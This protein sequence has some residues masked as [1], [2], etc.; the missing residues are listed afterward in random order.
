M[1]ENIKLYGRSYKVT[2]D[3]IEI[4]DLDVSFQV[5]KTLN[6]GEPNKAEVSV[7]N[8][9][10]DH[11]KQ[12]EGLGEVAVQIEAGYGDT[13]S[14]LFTGYLRTGST[15]YEGVDRVTTLSSADGE[16]AVRSKRIQ[17]TVSKNTSAS[18]VIRDLVKALGI[19]EG[20]LND[21]IGKIDQ[22]IDKRLFAEGTVLVGSPAREMTMICR[23]CGMLWSIQGGKLQLIPIKQA[24]DGEALEISSEHGL[25]GSPTVNNDKLMSCTILMIPDVYPGR[26][27]VMN[28]ARV[29]GQYRIETTSHH[30]D[31]SSLEWYVD[32]TAKNY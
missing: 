13:L 15:T 11:I 10:N 22:Q 21:A 26:K 9:N 17:K 7:Y 6:P 1:S 8:L 31:T 23:S 4:T 16:Q 3:T 27:L 29:T 2:I 24:L 19:G 28:A 32:I 25:V 20:N 30:G 18:D 14:T 5:D 12:L